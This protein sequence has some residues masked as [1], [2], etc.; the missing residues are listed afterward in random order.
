MVGQL[1]YY[2]N[3]AALVR[4]GK[5]NV[6]FG[7][8]IAAPPGF[9]SFYEDQYSRNNGSWNVYDNSTFG[10][11]PANLRIQRYMAANSVF[12]PGSAGC[13]QGTSLKLL[14]KR[15]SIGGNEFTAGMIDSKSAGLWFP[16]YAYYEF[17]AKIPHGHGLWPAWWMT[18]KN[19]GA[20]MCEWDV[21]EYF[22]SQ[23]PA[24]VSSTLHGTPVQPAD[25]S[26]TQLV[27]NRY[28]NNTNRTFFE[29][30]TY[31][32]SWRIWATEIVPVTDSIGDTL[33]DPHS[34]S[35]Y[36]RFRTLLDG[37]EQY[38]FVDT[39]AGYWSGA[40]GDENSFWNIYKQG[41]QVSG[42]YN[43]HPDHELAYSD[44]LNACLISGNPGACVTTRGG[45]NVIRAG[46]PGA[47]A[48]FADPATTFELD[49][50]YCAKYTG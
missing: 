23:L 28:T 10:A 16:R 43:G 1:R 45:Y 49:Y 4:P 40:G 24:K 39:S 20:S 18:A 2:N 34:P 27:S 36:V 48:T 29:A 42:K 9:T 15:E 21:M 35:T 19:G 26:L 3:G 22:H 47:I 7:H 11:D 32:P 5:P 31:T 25:G 12:G 33:A 41:C 44:Q 30:S 14:T 13:T 8:R 46:A 38:R 37:V 17:R 50:F 6:A